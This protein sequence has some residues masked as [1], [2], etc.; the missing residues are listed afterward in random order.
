ME[1]LE[2]LELLE[3]LEELDA[4]VPRGCIA[5]IIPTALE[6]PLLAIVPFPVAVLSGLRAYPKPIET[7][8]LAVS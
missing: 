1:L 7:A 4:V 3:E 6:T 5:S 8:V 2:L